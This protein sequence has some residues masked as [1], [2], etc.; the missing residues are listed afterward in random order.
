MTIYISRLMLWFLH[1]SSM[2]ADEVTA[3]ALLAADRKYYTEGLQVDYT[4]SVYS[5]KWIVVSSGD[6]YTDSLN[7]STSQEAAADN[8][9]R[10]GKDH[11]LDIDYDMEYR[12]N[13]EDNNSCDSSST[14]IFRSCTLEEDNFEQYVC[15]TSS[16][17]NSYSDS[18]EDADTNSEI[19]DRLRYNYRNC[20]CT[21]H[22]SDSTQEYKTESTDSLVS[23]YGIRT[24]DDDQDALY[25]HTQASMLVS[26]PVRAKSSNNLGIME[27]ESDLCVSNSAFSDTTDQA[28]LSI[29]HVTD[30]NAADAYISRVESEDRNIRSIVNLNSNTDIITGESFCDYICRCFCCTNGSI[31]DL[32]DL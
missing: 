18:S 31:C 11:A 9:C 8:T 1:S 6:T 5:T 22:S 24:V 21:D 7:S 32:M 19:I 14:R 4:D 30:S 23:S 27:E 2:M 13:L 29:L 3:D 17:S 16:G 25:M 10:A 20:D 28:Y 26:S 15:S 12:F